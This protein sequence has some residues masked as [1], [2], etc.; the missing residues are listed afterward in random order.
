MALRRTAQ[1]VDDQMVGAM[2]RQGIEGPWAAGERILVLIAG[3][4]MA[5]SLVRTGRR[6][7]DLMMDAPWTV[8]TVERPNRPTSSALAVRRVAE[9][10]KLAEQLG[11]SSVVLTGDDLPA[12]AVEFARRNNVTQIVVGKSHERFWKLISGRSLA[13]ALLK[14]SGGAAVHFVANGAPDGSAA[15][16]VTKP[17][18]QPD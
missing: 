8:G 7:S 9:A 3:D 17:A 11:G 13:H 1:T 14:Q 5:A 6:L 16:P 18:R 12:A 15:E 10:L 2:R 4:P